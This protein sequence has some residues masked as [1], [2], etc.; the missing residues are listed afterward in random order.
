MS[1]E[2]ALEKHDA[3]DEKLINALM[4]QLRLERDVAQTLVE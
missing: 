2:Q 1:E 3:E 4:T